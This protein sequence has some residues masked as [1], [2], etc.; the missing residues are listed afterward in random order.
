[1]TGIS[2]AAGLHGFCALVYLALGVMILA[3]APRG[4][5]AL[6]LAG[7][8]GAT[9]LWA[10]AVALQWPIPDHGLPDPTEIASAVAW[11]CFIFH[12]YR[13]SVANRRHILQAF[14]V[15]GVL[16]A[17]MVFALPLA[18]VLGFSRGSPGWALGAALRLGVAISSLLLLE[19]LYLNTAPE[20][21]WNINLLC[22]ALGGLFLYDLILYAD[23]ILFRK[24]SP[25]LLEA[26]AVVTVLSAPLIALAA[27]R[28][29][30]W[31]V[32]IHVS[33][34]VV[35]HG[36]SLIASGILLVGLAAAGEMARQNGV[37]WGQVA[38]ISVLFGGALAVA[39]VLTSGSMRSRLRRLL[40][41]H[42]FSHRFDYRREW[43]RCVDALTA[44]ETH[45]PLHQRAIRAAAEIVDSPAGV[46]FIR[47]PQDVSFQWAGSLNMP[48]VEMPVSPGHPL[49]P[50][51][52]ER[53]AVVLTE[54]MEPGVWFPGLPSLWLALPLHQFGGLIGFIL[55]AP[56][57]APFHL[58]EEVF[59]L[60]RVI[61]CEVAS[62]VA[63]QRAAQ[64]LSQTRQLRDYSE[65]FAFVAH[66]IKNVSG[67]LAMLLANAEIHA[68]NPD[69]QRDMLSTVRAS[70][71]RIT[72]LLGRLH[73][74][75]QERCQAL[76]SP[77]QRLAD[78]VALYRRTH[79]AAVV[80]HDRSAGTGIAMDPDAFDAV[81]SHLLDNAVE[82][83]GDDETVDIA[84]QAAGPQVWIDIKDRGP[85]M[86]PEFVRDKLFLP[87]STTKHNGHGIGAYQARAL[88]RS[89]GGDVVVLGR[90]AGGT[91]LRI[92]LPCVVVTD[93]T[94]APVPA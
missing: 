32:D 80:L 92:M 70:V 10:A 31:G 67:Q 37:R 73:A 11:Y 89:A 59:D 25:S 17:M 51:L 1:M 91:T 16:A 63:E 75:E 23:A 49:I 84:V 30:T 21:R 7:A 68:G 77:G 69:F 40:V 26:R 35:F 87:F 14:A 78:L 3:S 88:V 28:N 9:A 34:N 43:L 66:D 42:F 94:D 12:L 2:A 90:P 45:T 5:T 47:P 46:L 50:L 85:G 65:R 6:W 72:R 52:A 41:D 86:A 62:R 76:V 19:N 29:R 15:M 48:A 38:D 8:C 74:E 93:A 58:D 36:L 71:A 64:T 60:L 39:V 83:G 22:I 18:N 82:A 61:A 81:V 27:V 53:R 4:R 24:L 55:L 79:G 13:R 33:R 44:P 20:R 54:L 57:R 56:P